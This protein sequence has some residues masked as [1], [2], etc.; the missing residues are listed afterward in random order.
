MY[1]QASVSTRHPTMK[2]MFYSLIE[3]QYWGGLKGSHEDL[4]QVLA[5]NRWDFVCKSHPYHRKNHDYTKYL[6]FAR[7]NQS[8]NKQGDIKH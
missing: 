7:C 5:M 1:K 6:D 2:L 4:A 8:S 3:S